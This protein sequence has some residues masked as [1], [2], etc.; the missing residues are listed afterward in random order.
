MKNKQYNEL[1]VCG[2][3]AVKALAKEHPEQ[4]RRFYFSNERASL[5]G[6]LCKR[7][8]KQKSPYNLVDSKDLEKLS[9]TVHHQGV[10]AMINRIKLTPLTP[11]VTEGW[12]SKKENVLLLDRIGNANNLGAIVRSAAFFGIKNIIISVN[13]EQSAITTSTYRVA[14]GGMEYVS[15]Y[16]VR[17]MVRFLQDMQGKMVR[18]GTD[19]RAETY[20]S[21]LKTIC[22]NKNAI[23]VLGN[24]EY[25][26][27]QVVKENC[28]HLVVIPSVNM[29][30]ATDDTTDTNTP[31]ESLNVAQAAAIILYEVAKLK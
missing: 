22:G 5:F 8:A 11:S 15:I 3:A 28:D 24:E 23:I 26:I 21:N 6:D 13:E 27:S 30:T 20:V 29:A 14:Q 18:I 9:G 10:V 16:L 7:L 1:A 25:G 17:S 4:I 12:I 31:I 19:V 2:L